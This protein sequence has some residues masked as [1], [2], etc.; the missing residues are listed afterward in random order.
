M[1]DY[2]VG[3]DVG[4]TGSKAMVFDLG[5][6]IIGKG[7]REYKLDEPKPN[8]VEVG[9]Q[10]ILDITFEAVK[11][12]V[13][14]SGVDPADIK[15]IS[16]SVNRSSFCL[17]G[18]DMAVI[19][20]KMIVWLDSRAESVMEEMNA[21]ISPERRN[22]I[23]GMTSSTKAARARP[24]PINQP[25]RRTQPTSCPSNSGAESGAGV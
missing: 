21:K 7:Y 15:S 5:G 3:I 23:T 24:P 2:V 1:S 20:D 4:T 17:V 9:A 16:F 8:W 10:F 11:E 25:R 13:E 14:D 22:E 18:E 19:D 6:N 12:A